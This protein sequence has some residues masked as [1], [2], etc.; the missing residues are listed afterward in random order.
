MESLKP[1]LARERKQYPAKPKDYLTFLA[2]DLKDVP[3]SALISRDNPDLSIF[4]AKEGLDS[5]IK[6][7]NTMDPN[8]F[9]RIVRV[10]LTGKDLSNKALEDPKI[11]ENEYGIDKIE[12]KY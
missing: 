2:K 1:V 10:Y 5:R 7:P 8:M 3:V 9:K 4:S 11:S 12:K 6:L